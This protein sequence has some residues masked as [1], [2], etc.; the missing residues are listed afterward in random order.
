MERSAGRVALVTGANS[1]IG[2]AT[3]RALL[4]R[5][6][7]VVG[8]D[9]RIDRVQES[10][11]ELKDAPGR[12]YPL[13]CDVSCEENVLRAFKWIKEN[14]GGVDVLINS[15]GICRENL[16][17]TGQT[18]VWRHTLDVNVLGLSVCTREAVQSMLDRGVDDGFVIHIS[19]IAGHIM[20]FDPLC[21]MYHASKH[22]VRALL[23]GLRKDLVARNSKIRCGEISP[24]IVKTDIYNN[25]KKYSLEALENMHTPMMEPEDIADA[26]IYMLSQPP[27]VQVLYSI[28][29][30]LCLPCR[31]KT[32]DLRQK[33]K[34]AR[35][36]E[37]YDY[38]NVDM[39]KVYGRLKK[40]RLSQ[41]PSVFEI[42]P[43][44]WT[45]ESASHIR[46]GDNSVDCT[47]KGGYAE[48]L[49]ATR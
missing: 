19:S 48:V 13:Q 41:V 35:S 30:C 21:S 24:G 47:L 26:V 31:K 40:R 46:N 38:R 42:F 5:G 45:P 17:T 36:T 12:L 27:R 15:A 22:A 29:C 25:L 34:K 44:Q 11:R 6:L 10:A 9:K 2:A 49:E 4:R 8:L 39:E 28:L 1:G 33:S 3:A 20:P 14:L 18:A 7:E 23:E 32:R 37:V 16:P 43:C